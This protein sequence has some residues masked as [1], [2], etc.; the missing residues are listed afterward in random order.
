M[1]EELR[2]VQGAQYQRKGNSTE[3][4]KFCG[5]M[6]EKR[7]QKCPAFRKKCAK[8]GRENHFAAKCKA[9]LEQGRKKNV[10]TITTECVSD[11]SEDISC[12]TVTE[13]EIVDAVETDSGKDV[14][15]ESGD[16]KGTDKVK[17]TQL[18]YAGMLLDKNMVKFQIDCGASCN[19]IPIN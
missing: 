12:I 19:V 11:E 10:S 18:L 15:P 8:C 5:K 7:K 16:V 9:K 6:H 1:V 4:C 17:D 14:D 13:T 2:A 3:E